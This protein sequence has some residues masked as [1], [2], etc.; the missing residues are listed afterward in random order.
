MKRDLSVA[1]KILE[2][3]EEN[4]FQNSISSTLIERAFSSDGISPSL[5]EQYQMDLLINGGFIYAIPVGDF[6]VHDCRLT[7]AGHD[8][9]DSL[10]AAKR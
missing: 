8:L 10:R 5:Y 9:L 6:G 3:I 2:F 7:W 4:A 1:L